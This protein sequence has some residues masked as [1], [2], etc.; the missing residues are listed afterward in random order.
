MVVVEDEERGG[1]GLYLFFWIHMEG[2]ESGIELYEEK[3][4]RTKR[5]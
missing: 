4:R 2:R 3:R 1:M 5:S